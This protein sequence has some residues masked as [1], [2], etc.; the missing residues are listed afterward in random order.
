MAVFLYIVL[1]C[2]VD[3]GAGRNDNGK[4]V[5]LFFYLSPECLIFQK[6]QGE[7]GRRSVVP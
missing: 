5:I 3:Q 2:P 4:R 7:D 1:H 6:P